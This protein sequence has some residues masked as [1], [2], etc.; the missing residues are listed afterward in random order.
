[1]HTDWRP[2]SPHEPFHV[3]TALW[4]LDDFTAEN[5]ATRVV[6]G[7]HRDPRPLPKSFRAPEARH[8]NEQLVA[9]RAG[10]VLV[11]N[12][13]LLHSGTRNRSD[14]PRRVV[15]CPFVA[16]ELRPPRDVTVPEDAPEIVR[17]LF[18]A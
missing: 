12:G 15:Q 1:M 3:A 8:P 13:H 14:A 2:R 17:V 11:F 16:A 6:P 10:D 7:S 4:L 9:A 5:G 18:G